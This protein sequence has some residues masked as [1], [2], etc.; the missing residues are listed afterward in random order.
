MVTILSTSNHPNARWT[1]TLILL[2]IGQIALLIYLLYAKGIILNSTT[3]ISDDNAISTDSVN[4]NNDNNLEH[5]Q[6]KPGAI[7]EWVKQIDDAHQKVLRMR[8]HIEQAESERNDK[9]DEL[10]KKVDELKKQIEETEQKARDMKDK[11]GEAEDRMRHKQKRN[12]RNP[13]QIKKLDPV[14]SVTIERTVHTV[15]GLWDDGKEP[16]TENWDKWKV[17]HPNFNTIIH[18]KKESDQLIAQ[19]F[20]WLK[21]IYDI[22]NP[23]EK[24]DLLRLIYV[25]AYGGIYAD[26]DVGPSANFEDHLKKAG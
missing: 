25:Y 6:V 5:L 26:L 15:Y 22:I 12:Y 21:P 24:A 4:N 17:H 14:E 7:T 16:N 18:T 2:F 19:N 20:T 10:Q 13:E 11:A 23:I 8:E 9:K 3:T 1:S